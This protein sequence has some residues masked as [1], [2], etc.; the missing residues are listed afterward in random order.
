LT[1]G[2][3]DGYRLRMSAIHP[4]KTYRITHEPRLSQAALAAQLG[5]ARMTV[6]RW[7][8]DRAKIDVSLIRS[9]AEKTGIPAKE[10][11][12]DLVELL[13]DEAAE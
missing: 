13:A 8:N 4:L 10:L 1:S 7:E 5:V 12:P 6:I 2:D 11:R 3:T 9:V